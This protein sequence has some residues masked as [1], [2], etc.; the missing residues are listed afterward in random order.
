MNL[1]KV[2]I[3]GAGGFAREVLDVF[4]ALDSI[5]PTFDVIGYIVDPQYGMPG[6][7]MN[8]KPIL[9]GFDWF[10]EH[11]DDVQA[12][13]GVGTSELRMGLVKRAQ[14]MGVHFCSV[15]HPNAILTRWVTIGEGTVIT[16]GCILT[17][18]IQI[19]NHVH[20]NLDCTLG[21][22]VVIE[23]FVTLAPGVHVSG[24]VTLREGCYIGTGS[25]IIEKREIGA[26]SIVG[27]GS[28]VI[29][30]VPQNT[31]VVGVPGRVIQ[32]RPYGWHLT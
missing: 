1:Q 31:T 12:I 23:D 28:T 20:I 17:N 32:T 16:A 30:D 22:D 29:T 5:K 13:C 2:V 6:T 27:A 15:V 4:D 3:I 8:D 11:K 25:N 14:E 18:Q 26:W 10:G 9:G 21:H 24:N 19:G 7:Y